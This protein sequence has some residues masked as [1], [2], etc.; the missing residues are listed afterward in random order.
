VDNTRAIAV[1]YQERYPRHIRVLWSNTNVGMAANLARV[2]GLARGTYVAMCEGDDYWTDNDK[3]QKQVTV[4][5]TNEDI[6]MV[7]TDVDCHHLESGRTIRRINRHN[8]N[9]CAIV[10]LTDVFERIY[11]GDYSVRT[12]S[13]VIRNG[14]LQEVLN[15]CPEITDGRFAMSDTLLWLELSRKT[16][17][18]YLNISTGVYNILSE[19]ASHSR[20]D[21]RLVKF[22]ESMFDMAEFYARKYSIG[23]RQ[24]N[25]L[26]ARYALQ[27]YSQAFMSRNRSLGQLAYEAL[28]CRFTSTA[29]HNLLL[30]GLSK[31]GSRWWVAMCYVFYRAARRLLKS[32]EYTALRI[33]YEWCPRGYRTRGS[34]V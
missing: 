15:T 13:V 24:L 11:C 6:G 1:N 14:L 19:S 3:L 9:H 10:G 4:L 22:Y 33:K 17:I 18:G 8:C 2:V 28:N 32:A 29:L 7:H 25:E 34:V 12:L 20:S 5:E 26:K 23:Q 21:R 16:R 27:L 31:D 30:R